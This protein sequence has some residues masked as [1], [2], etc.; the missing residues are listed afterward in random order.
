MVI[1]RSR[2]IVFLILLVTSAGVVA[3]L[4]RSRVFSE[5]EITSSSI[6]EEELDSPLDAN[7]GSGGTI[8][9]LSI[10]SLRAGTYPGSDIVIEEKLAPGSNYQRYLTSYQ[11]EGNTIYA[12]LTIPNGEMPEGGWPAII[13]NHGYIPPAQYR[14]TEKYIAY[15]NAFSRS[16]YV[17]FRP[18]YRGHGDSEG[19]PTGAYGSN[20][21]TIDVLNALSSVKAVKNP[22]NSTTHIVNAD[23][24]GMWGH[25]MGGFITLRSMVVSNDIKAGV[26]WAGVVASYPDLI[27]NWHR[28]GQTPFSPPPELAQSTRRWRQAL[29][30]DYG[31]PESNPDFWNS[32]SA[33]SYL[34][35]VSGPIQIHHGTA[36]TSVPVEFSQTLDAQLKTAGKTSEIFLYPG[37]DHNLA[38]NLSVALQRSVDFFDEH[39]KE[40]KRD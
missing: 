28:P 25:S 10:A 35:D 11:S 17:L 30:E 22:E 36:D 9:P 8:H 19:E 2:W 1:F 3:Y 23:K 34:N 21:Y 37:D 7:T 5:N 15:T 33:N 27:N 14:T 24:I 13:F 18:D 16:G 40:I 20:G 12:L 31:T 32:L 26:I 38:G 29:V 6:F 4:N 39:L